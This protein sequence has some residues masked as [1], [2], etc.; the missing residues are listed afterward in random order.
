M[1]LYLHV[2]NYRMQRAAAIAMRMTHFCVC[3]ITEIILTAEMRWLVCR[4]H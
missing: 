4:N 1:G 3:L 2:K